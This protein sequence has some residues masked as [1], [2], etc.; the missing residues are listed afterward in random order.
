MK[1]ATV[2]MLMLTLIAVSGLADVTVNYIVNT[3]TLQ[4]VTDSTHQV[5]IC[6]AEVGPEGVDK[7]YN[8]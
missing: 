4:G 2:L 3:S 7:W 6:G 1:K 5:Q 8:L